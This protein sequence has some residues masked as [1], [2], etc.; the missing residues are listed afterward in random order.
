LDF[1]VK[2]L[3]NQG[4]QTGKRISCLGVQKQP[5]LWAVGKRKILWKKT[6]SSLS[7]TALQ[8]LKT[9]T[10]NESPYCTK[11]GLC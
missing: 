1:F 11:I 2:S 10:K 8:S 4:I 9:E 7:V 3:T 5:E 6:F